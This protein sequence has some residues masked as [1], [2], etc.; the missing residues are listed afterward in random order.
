METEVI[1][2]LIK[3]AWVMIPVLSVLGLL[4]YIVKKSAE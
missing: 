2:E 4:A 3:L 1:L